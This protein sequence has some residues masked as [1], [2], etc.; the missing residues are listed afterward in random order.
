V[1]RIILVA[2]AL[3]AALFSTPAAGQVEPPVAM[4]VHDL[5][6]RAARWGMSVAEV[7]AAFP[8]EAVRLEPEERLEDGNVVAAGM[9]T[10]AIAGVQ[11][12][13]RFVFTSGRLS[14]VSL[15]TLEADSATP[16][17]YAR[18]R[19]ALA[20]QFGWPGASTKDDNFIDLRETRWRLGRTAV[21]AKYAAAR[22]GS[23]GVLAVVWSPWP[24]P[25][26][27]PGKGGTG[28]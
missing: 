23:P 27:A 5:G 26:P 24:P 11:L 6:W 22:A 17:V 1:I 16:E 19:A 20:A 4:P 10:Y 13:V 15:R 21:E 3:T 25:A 28:K 2:A 8:G 9:D 18:V 12:R 7:L 14:L